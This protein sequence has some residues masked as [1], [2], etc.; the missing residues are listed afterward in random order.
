MTLHVT[1][2]PRQD[3][4]GFQVMLDAEGNEMVY[5]DNATFVWNA[6]DESDVETQ[7]FFRGYMV[8]ERVGNIQ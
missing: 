8:C 5:S 7:G 1:V 6:V 2:D 3:V 4:L